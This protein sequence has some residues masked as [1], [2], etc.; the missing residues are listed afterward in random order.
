MAIN[1]SPALDSAR[2]S[3][4]SLGEAERSDDQDITDGRRNDVR[5]DGQEGAMDSV[6]A[7]SGIYVKKR[8]FRGT[9]LTTITIPT[10]AG[11]VY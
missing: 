3:G 7:E 1:S 11:K 10:F 8:T 6:L 9:Y 5:S 2:K 4:E